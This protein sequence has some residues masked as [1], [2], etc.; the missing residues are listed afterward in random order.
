MFDVELVAARDGRIVAAV[1]AEGSALA[2]PFEHTAALVE[3]M[4]AQTAAPAA[5]RDPRGA[6]YRRRS[7]R[8]W[9]AKAATNAGL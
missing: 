2:D 6:T 3:F 9:R 4:R 7:R 1:T 8:Y 5:V